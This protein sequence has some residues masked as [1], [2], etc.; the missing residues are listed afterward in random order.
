[1]PSIRYNPLTGIPEEDTTSG[2]SGVAGSFQTD[3]A[4]GQITVKP[5]GSGGGLGPFSVPGAIADAGSGVGGTISGLGS[6]LGFQRPQTGNLENDKAGYAGIQQTA[7]QTLGQSMATP[8][9]AT[10]DWIRA[11]AQG[12]NITQG[13]TAQSNAASAA[14]VFMDFNQANQARAGQTSLASQL[15]RQAA[16]QGPSVAQEQLRQATAANI[17]QQLAAAK[18]LHGNARLAALRQAGWQNAGIQQQA[19]SQ[20]TALRAQEI[21]S[22]Q[23]ALGNLFS[24]QRGQDITGAAQQAALQQGTNLANAGFIQGTNLANAQLAQG[25]SQFNANTMNAGNQFNA[26]QFNNAANNYAQQANAG[27]TAFGLAGLNSQLQT[28]SLNTQRQN[29]YINALLQGQQGISGLDSLIYGGNA[30]YDASKRAMVGGLLNQG[31]Q[32]LG[33]GAK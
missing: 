6:M 20:S 21:A 28:N 4:T 3:P 7:G 22:A 33:F 19:N 8:T 27:N 1:M 12:A 16:G 24:T 30:A 10:P 18:A 23:N 9:V 29:E 32:A 25:A 11:N 17:N 13:E 2:N 31:G 5:Q 26:T 14:P 15:Q